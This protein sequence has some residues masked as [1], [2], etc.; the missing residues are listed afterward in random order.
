VHQDEVVGWLLSTG[1]RGNGKKVAEKL[2]KIKSV[3][4]AKRATRR[5]K[6]RTLCGLAILAMLGR[7]GQDARATRLN[8]AWPSWPCWADTGKMLVPPDFT[9]SFLDN[10]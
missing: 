2:S 3:L 7:H 4:F 10:S 8:V 5:K 6:G 1:T 9:V